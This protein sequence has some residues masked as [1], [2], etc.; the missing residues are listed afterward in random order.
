M[1]LPKQDATSKRA[2]YGQ[3]KPDGTLIT[4]GEFSSELAKLLN[5]HPFLARKKEHLKM[6][7]SSFNRG[8][9]VSDA[10]SWIMLKG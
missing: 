10:Y 2:T 3:Q 6:A 8:E 4:W 5:R 7:V 9:S 1:K